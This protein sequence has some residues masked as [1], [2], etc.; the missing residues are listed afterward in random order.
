[1][2]CDSGKG[3]EAEE[4]KNQDRRRQQLLLDFLSGGHI[5]DASVSSSRNPGEE[6]AA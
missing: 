2:F 3:A 1:M 6:K 5:R 4:D